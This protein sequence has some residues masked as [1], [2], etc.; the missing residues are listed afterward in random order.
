MAGNRNPYKQDAT[1]L[2][3]Q[4]SDTPNFLFEAGYR[5][6]PIDSNTVHSA[7]TSTGKSYSGDYKFGGVYNAGKFPDPAGHKTS[8][9][10]LIYG[11]ASQ[12]LYRSDAGSNRGLDATFGFDWS[13][14]DVARENEQITAG[15]KFNAPFPNRKRDRVAC[16]LVYSKI[17]DPFRQFGALLGGAPLGSEKAWE[18]NYSVQLTP[19]FFVEPTFQYY[20]DV[21]ANR[22]LPNATVLGFRTKINF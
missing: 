22:T 4:I 15:V 3:F 18:V 19:Y 2:N 20:L 8:G 5:V 12:A 11:M 6:S 17:S 7:G 13:P 10:Y 14:G 16:G 9:N 21:G 1:G